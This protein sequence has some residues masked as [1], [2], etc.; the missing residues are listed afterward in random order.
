[1]SGLL[2]ALCA[3]LLLTTEHDPSL[4][5]LHQGWVVTALQTWLPSCQKGP[6]S[7][8][9][10]VGLQNDEETVAADPKLCNQFRRWRCR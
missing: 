7:H 10:P 5:V 2:L 6:R 8:D 1:M 4:L 3:R 9:V